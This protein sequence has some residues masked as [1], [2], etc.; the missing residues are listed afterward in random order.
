MAHAVE[1]VLGRLVMQEGDYGVVGPGPVGLPVQGRGIRGRW[2][3]NAGSGTEKKVDN[4]V[5]PVVAKALYSAVSPLE[6]ASCT[7]TPCST[8]APM[9]CRRPM[10]VAAVADV[11]V[12][13]LGQEDLHFR[14]K[15]ERC[16]LEDKRNDQT[17]PGFL[18]LKV[19]LF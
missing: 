9:I 5:C 12:R 13:A 16:R 2:G 18:I 17:E 7:F 11:G 4:L 15:A 19:H 10:I 8:R 14:E 1:H 3:V 6:S